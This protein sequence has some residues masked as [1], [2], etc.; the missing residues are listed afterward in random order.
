MT[1]TT[2]MPDDG[3]MN[4]VGN[5][6]NIVGTH[7]IQ[8]E[9]LATS[10]DKVVF[11]APRGYRVKS[12][13]GRVEVAGNDAGAVTAVIK[14]AASGTA[15][16]SGTALHSGTFNLKGTAATNQTLTLSATSSDLDIPAG[17]SIGV[18]FTGVLTLAT[19]VFTVALAPV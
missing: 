6:T 18:D 3:S 15:I 2:V 17:T 19:G 13:V 1:V 16:A 10:V 7:T 8:F 12:I 11:T 14:K 9:Y 5:D 4:F